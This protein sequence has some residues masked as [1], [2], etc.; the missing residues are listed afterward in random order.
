[1][2][3]VEEK[4]IINMKAAPKGRNSIEARVRM[5]L[6]GLR[7]EEILIS[8]TCTSTKG[9]LLNLEEEDD[10]PLKPKRSPYI[11]KFDS[12]SY[13]PFYFQVGRG[14]FSVEYTEGRSDRVFV[15]GRG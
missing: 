15:C 3:I 11:H 14:R 9:M 5:V 6:D 13:A 8:A 2:I 7:Q 12:F 10:E 1:M 4:Y